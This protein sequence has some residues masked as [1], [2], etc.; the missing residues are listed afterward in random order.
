MFF[1][2]SRTNSLPSNS[3]ASSDNLAAE[4]LAGRTLPTLILPAALLRL[5]GIESDQI[6]ACAGEL[7]DLP[8]VDLLQD[9]DGAALISV[10][11]LSGRA[12]CFGAAAELGQ[13]LAKSLAATRAKFPGCLIFPGRVAVG[14]RGVE[15]CNEQ[16]LSDLA[17]APPQLGGKVV[18]TAHLAHGL[19][20]DYELEALH[21]YDGPSGRRVPLWGLGAM[22]GTPFLVHNAEVF[23]RQAR[24]P[25][26]ELSAALR[27]AW[28]DHPALRLVGAVGVGKSHA[29]LRLLEG[30]NPAL[31]A[32]LRLDA[33]LPGRPR[34]LLELAR[35]LGLLVPGVLPAQLE[36][37]PRLAAAQLA[38]ACA[39]VKSSLGAAP[40]LLL[41][42]LQAAAARDRALLEE[43]VPALLQEGAARLL[44][45]EQIGI[46]STDALPAVVV[47]RFDPAEARA[48]AEQLLQRLEI[49]PALEQA[50]V[51]AAG[52]NALALEEMVL[53]LAHRGFMRRVYGSF[54]YAGNEE[55]EPETSLRLTAALEAAAACLGPVLPLRIL[56]LAEGPVEPGHLIEACGKFTV[57]LPW[58]FEEVFIEA[59]FLEPVEGGLRFRSEAQRLAFAGSVTGDGARSL[60]HALGGVLA[61]SDRHGGWSAYRLLAGTPEALPSLLDVGREHDKAPREEVF[62]ALFNEYR[63]HRARRSSD[64][65]T[66]LEILWTLLPLARRLGCLGNLDRELERAI[67]LA[68]R[69]PQR[70]VALVALRAENEQERG[71]PREA[72]RLFRQ[73]L[74]ASEGFDEARRATLMVRLGALL[75]RQE[76]WTEAREIFQQLLEVVDRRGATPVG[77][78]CRFYLGNIALAERRLAEAEIHHEAA[79]KLRRSR[80]AW[81]AL[82]ASLTAQAAVALAQGDAPRALSRADEAEAL[83]LR[84][85]TGNDELAFV[86]LGKGRALAQLGDFLTAQKTLRQALDL[87]RGRDDVLGEA[88]V[89]IELGRLNLRLGN[90]PQALEEARRAHFQLSLVGPSSQLG[91]VER[92]LGCILWQQRSW[93][94]AKKHLNEAI[95][96]H[97]RLGDRQELA[98]DTGCRLA[99]AVEQGRSQEIFHD[100]QT[101]ER[102]LEE[103]PHPAA[104]EVLYFRLF[105]GQEW[106][107][108][109]G[110]EVGDKT[111]PLRRSYQELLRKTQFLEPSRRHQF[112]FQIVEHQ[113]ILDIATRLDI[114]MPILTFNRQAILEAG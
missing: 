18:V 111:G 6:A 79:A 69:D 19:G 101:L 76:R 52:G 103:L 72:E 21:P 96:I 94:E 61:E 71:R 66:E 98:Q 80:F 68:A 11:P 8:G 74:A 17:T 14:P 23:G 95:A 99:L 36:E 39:R 33:G 86:L 88:I 47:E 48:A 73:A 56:A 24:V 35:W 91:Q 82:G 67:E 109:N 50:L 12:N 102:L 44:L 84:H 85:E 42:G 62:N 51:A 105:R 75:H 26:P 10:R 104:A 28:L 27:Q 3:V 65:A 30:E 58:G 92:L 81:K 60:R 2:V 32:R 59:D 4:R 49:P 107:E 112:L 13:E 41:D 64:E 38:D 113:E 55:V 70:R 40:I 54:F 1:D 78:T 100:T 9:P 37:D 108:K 29:A 7:L 16:L 114:S 87:R 5:D 25:R 46:T 97:H 93:D 90:L 63:E 22:R 20:G 45:C 110:F 106:L 83:I 31:V 15:P 77:A 34:L 57:D 89:R 43:L 53:R